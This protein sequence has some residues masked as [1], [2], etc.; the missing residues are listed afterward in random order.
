MNRFTL[1]TST[2]AAATLIASLIIGQ[3]QATPDRL[4]AAGLKTMVAGLGYEVKD[5]NTEVGKEKYEFAV[6]KKSFN[7]PIGTELSNSKNYVWLTVFLGPNSP[8]KPHED[9]LKAN[10]SIQPSFFYITTKGNLMMA[11]AIDN[12]DITPAILR[13]VID[14][15][16]DDVDAN[17][18]LWQK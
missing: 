8:T 16:S 6:K 18:A 2:I 10:Y 14:K 13:R 1:V 3:T 12:R 4:D 17:S 15:L 11:E 9:L 5:L 7:I